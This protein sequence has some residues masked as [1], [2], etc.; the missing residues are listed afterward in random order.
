MCS[1][2][3]QV[4][5]HHQF[6]TAYIWTSGTTGT[7]GTFRKPKILGKAPEQKPATRCTAV[8]V[9]DNPQDAV[10]GGVGQPV[11]AQW[12]SVDHFHLHLIMGLS[13]DVAPDLVL[14]VAQ[15]Q[16]P[17]CS[18]TCNH[19]K[20]NRDNPHLL[21]NQARGNFGDN[22]NFRHKAQRKAKKWQNPRGPRTLGVRT[23]PLRGRGSGRPTPPP[24]L[25]AYLSPPCP[26]RTVLLTPLPPC[27]LH[28]SGTLPEVLHRIQWH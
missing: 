4:E 16:L 17:G 5:H 3:G 18:A 25:P 12:D 26:R 10:G 2:D 9:C 7:T 27:Q 15:R 19:F 20:N 13:C 22:K 11:A 24:A 23:P 6:A 28:F 1:L 21:N 14:G 8:Q